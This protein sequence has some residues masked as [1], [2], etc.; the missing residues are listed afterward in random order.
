V[1]FS[2]QVTAVL[3]EAYGREYETEHEKFL[4]VTAAIFGL[5]REMGDEAFWAAA[6]DLLADHEAVTS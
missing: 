6:N 2:D 1:S 4:A 5:K 3:D